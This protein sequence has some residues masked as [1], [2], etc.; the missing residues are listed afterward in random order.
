MDAKLFFIWKSATVFGG[1]L[2]L[3]CILRFI[4]LSLSSPPYSIKYY[5]RDCEVTVMRTS[6]MVTF[7]F[8]ETFFT[9]VS[10]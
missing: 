8:Y 3:I 2:K 10:E 1:S 4:F 7:S 9:S 6:L 5:L